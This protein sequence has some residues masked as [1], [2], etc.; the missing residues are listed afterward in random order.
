MLSDRGLSVFC[1]V[2]CLEVGQVRKV[3]L[4]V[5]VQP[6]SQGATE[7]GNGTGPVLEVDFTPHPAGFGAR[8]P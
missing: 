5:V 6:G 4:C 2:L 3:A 1:L 8:G 7:P